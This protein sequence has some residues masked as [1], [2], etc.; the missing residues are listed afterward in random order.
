MVVRPG[1][2]FGGGGTDKKTGGRA[3]DGR[4]KDAQAFIGSERDGQDYK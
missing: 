1:L 4:I 2:L 3:G